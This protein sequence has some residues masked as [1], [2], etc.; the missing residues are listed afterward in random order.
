MQKY[1]PSQGPGGYKGVPE[2]GAFDV[3]VL[4]GGPAGIAAATTAAESGHSTL[5][6][7]RLGFCGGAAVSGMSGTICGLYMTVAEP[8]V[9]QPRQIIFGFAERFRAALDKERGLT[10]PQIYGKTWVTTHDC[11][12]YKK[13]ATDLLRGAGVQ[14]LYHTEMV[15]VIT[16]DDALTGLVLHTRSGFTRVTAKRVIDASGDADAVFRMGLTTTK[17]NNG[18][19]QNPSMMFKIGNVDRDTYLNYWGDDTISPLKVVEKLE[20][21][22]ELLRKKV[23]L[24]PTVNPG[25]ILVNGTKIT[26][27]DG[28]DLDVTNPVD[29]S[30]AEQFSI[31]QAKAFFDFLKEEIPGCENAYFI[32][33]AQEV[34]VRQTRSIEGVKRLMNDDVVNTRKTKDSIARSSWPIELHYGAK[35]KTEWLVDDYYDVPFATLVPKQGRNVIVAGRCLSAEHEALASCRVTAQCFE[36]GRAAALAAD[37]SIRE[38][39]DFQA[40]DGV[41]ISQRMQSAG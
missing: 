33:Y 35:P 13:V 9:A 19:I 2:F 14:I 38:G 11:A 5:L 16:E 23:W 24:F 26:G 25:E 7:E 10:A 30:E 34:G 15:D 20:K 29:H 37:M 21:R 28:R 4:G 41:E 18:V 6:I 3:I 1:L 31:Y 40:I 17:G 8:N 22:D 39:M 12:K 32:D 36:Y 27:F